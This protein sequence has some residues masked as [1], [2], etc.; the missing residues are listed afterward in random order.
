MSAQIRSSTTGMMTGKNILGEFF[1]KRL[2]G[3]FAA[4]VFLLFGLGIF[5]AARAQGRA[6]AGAVPVTPKDNAAFDM[7][8]YWVSVVDEDWRWRM[9]TP[10][11]GDY[12]SVPLND[13]GLKI[14][15]AWD[16]KKDEADGNQCKAYGAGN[17]M[18]MPERLHI[19][20]ENASTMRMD[21][22]AGTQARLFHFDCSKW[23][24]GATPDW[25]GD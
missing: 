19:T 1:S 9:L 8:G 3:Q 24:H 21:I 11:K 12:I 5:S 14:A 23:Q 22:D 13:A 15:E 4:V 10:A 6:A 16:P 17:I 2:A 25:Q 18:R 20:W 7:T